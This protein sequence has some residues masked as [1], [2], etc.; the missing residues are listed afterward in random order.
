[1]IAVRVLIRV[2]YN[3]ANHT[4]GREI[5][6]KVYTYLIC[7]YNKVLPLKVLFSKFS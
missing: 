3:D 2:K 6:T 1:M 4:I 5:D 7:I